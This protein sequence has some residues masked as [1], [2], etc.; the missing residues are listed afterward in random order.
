VTLN[1]VLRQVTPL[2]PVA[3]VILL[4]PELRHLLEE[5]GRF[6]FW[7]APLQVTLSREDMTRTIEE[8]VRTATLLSPRK[9]GALIVLERETGLSDIAA[10]GVELDAEVS[11]ELLATLFHVG[12]PLHDGAVIVRGG[13]IVAAGCR[14]PLS[15]SP[16]IATNVHMRHRAAIGVSEQSDAAVVVVSEERG[17]ISLALGGKLISGLKDDTLRGRLVEAFGRKV[18]KASGPG[19]PPGAS[20]RR[21][22]ALGRRRGASAGAAGAAAATE[23]EPKAGT[24]SP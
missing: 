24:L 1:W 16:N 11:S 19:G 18:A 20:V 3:I 7:G 21:M 23:C 13:R 12:T 2:G 22:I 10:T 5:L 14:L 17:T 8:V 4:Y 9:T 6:G 15:D